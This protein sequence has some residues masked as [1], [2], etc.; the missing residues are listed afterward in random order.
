[1]PGKFTPE[2]IRK[3]LDLNQMTNV[4]SSPMNP[5][6]SRT[7]IRN[8]TE[9]GSGAKFG[10]GDHV[11]VNLHAG[12]NWIDTLQSFLVF[13]VKSIDEPALF[14]NSALNLF[15]ES[16]IVADNRDVDRTRFLN[17]LNYHRMN[18][19]S[20]NQKDVNY[21][22]LFLANT[23]AVR[24]DVATLEAKGERIQITAGDS[25]RV[26]IPL[27]WLGGIFDSYKLMPP[28]LARG[29]RVDLTCES[30][31]RA[32][33]QADAGVP[34]GYEITKVSILTDSYRMEQS[35]LE[36]INAQYASSK[37]GLIYEY[38]SYNTEKTAAQGDTI[39]VE[40]NQSSSQTV[41]ALICASL[42]ADKSDVAKDSFKSAV[43]LDTVK[44]QWRIGPHFMPNQ[45]TEGI[46]EHYA[47]YLYYADMLRQN[48]EMASN[49]GRFTGQAHADATNWGYGDSVFA[50]TFRR[51]N[52]VDV[53]G[54]AVN[55]NSSLGFEAEGLTADCDVYVFVR[56]LRRAVLF[57]QSMTLET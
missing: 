9:G 16:Q 8:Y 22:A 21:N 7:Q 3:M 42:T 49:Y 56:H 2:T 29:L 20:Q 36:Y 4:R 10:P 31:Q 47:Q 18:T 14:R 54:M 24:A 50:Q 53:S 46:T 19:M 25:T 33:T 45:L 41:D 55:K 27:K 13:D 32:L 17:Q 35:I 52:V 51:S 5:A 26:M 28:H 38:Y 15:S 57:L 34:T 1:M 44:S 40:F 12:T 48:L 39:N 23:S 37:T 6:I 30:F 11:I 43:L